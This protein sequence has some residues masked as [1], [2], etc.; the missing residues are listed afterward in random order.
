MISVELA[1]II[2]IIIILILIIDYTQY[3]LHQELFWGVLMSWT[4]MKCEIYLFM[5]SCS[6]AILDP[7][8]DTSQLDQLFC[9]SKASEKSSGSLEDNGNLDTESVGVFDLCAWLLIISL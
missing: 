2:I 6:F 8:L 4:N 5:L 3:W 9:R 1:Q 7:L